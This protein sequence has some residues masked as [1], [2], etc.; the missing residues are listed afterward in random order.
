[1]VLSG[2]S[3]VTVTVSSLIVSRITP[4]RWLTW[5]TTDA[6][7]LDRRLDLDLHDRLE[8]GRL[9]VRVGLAEA[10][11]RG[12]LERHFGRVDRVVQRRR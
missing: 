7:E 3:A 10:H 1:M 4:R 2:T 5:P 12:G 6:L 8:D 9:G 11:Q